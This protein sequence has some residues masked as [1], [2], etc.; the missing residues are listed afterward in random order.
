MRK[1]K[2]REEGEQPRPRE[3]RRR[4]PASAAADLP[5]DNN[6][7]GGVNNGGRNNSR[8]QEIRQLQQLVR[9]YPVSHP[10][11]RYEKPPPPRDLANAKDQ[12]MWTF[13]FA[14]MHRFA[15]DTFGRVLDEA[16][17]RR[18]PNVEKRIQRMMS[19]WSD[20]LL[21]RSSTAYSR[22]RAIGITAQLA[23]TAYSRLE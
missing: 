15:I 21:D 6:D 17:I 16:E 20:G 1:K 14:M 5:A 2:T 18:E 4:P 10:R 3:R 9:K 8:E 23:L 7:V 11:E 22:S 19:E 12:V 13:V